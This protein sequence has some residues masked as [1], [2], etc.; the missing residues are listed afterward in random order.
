LGKLDLELC[1]LMRCRRD[2]GKDVTASL[3]ES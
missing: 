2:S 3:F 1:G